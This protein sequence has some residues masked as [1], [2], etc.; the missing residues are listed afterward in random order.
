MGPLLALAMKDLKLLMRSP[1]NLFFTFAF[2]LLLALFFGSIFGG[3]GAKGSKLNVAFV[4]LDGGPL[5]QDFAKD[6]AAD[7]ALAATEVKSR[8]RR[9]PPKRGCSPASSTSSRSGRSRGC[10]PIRRA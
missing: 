9:A 1:A 6:L 5:S 4:N 10:S 2:P 3:A 7:D 8:T